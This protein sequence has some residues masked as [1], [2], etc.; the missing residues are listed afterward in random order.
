M[1]PP[2]DLISQAD[3]VFARLLE[4]ADAYAED[5]RD[6]VRFFTTHGRGF[7]PK[8]LKAY[9]AD[10][11][12][13][14]SNGTIKANTFNKRLAGA[15]A[16]VR[17]FLLQGNAEL[18]AAEHYR[19]EALLKELTPVGAKPPAIDSEKLPTDAELER[20]ARESRDALVV[21]IVPFLAETGL[22][23]SEALA[24]RM[25]DLAQGKAGYRITVRGKGN[26]EREI[27][28]AAW[29]VERAKRRYG[30][31]T[32]LFEHQGKPY[33][34]IGTTVRIK[35][36]SRAVLGRSLSPHTFRHYFATRLL[37]EGKSLKA[38]S[39][40]LGHASTQTT[41]DIYQHEAL[42]WADLT[43]P[44]RRTLYEGKRQV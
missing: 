40:F 29:L 2:K 44:R 25:T 14:Y 39:R 32:F 28:A 6:L 16:R 35:A 9:Y 38:V 10:L 15:K 8:G 33:S 41:A 19:I 30:G 37:R 13:R 21:T 1:A 17:L 34:R 24:I 43:D 18:S 3:P 12:E 42:G 7:T 27:L 11:K 22:R 20:L 4:P 36:E 23:I 26:K 5:A 31:K